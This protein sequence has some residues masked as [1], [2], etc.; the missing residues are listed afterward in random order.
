MLADEAEVHK[1]E[2]CNKMVPPLQISSYFG[3]ISA[4]RNY[5]PVMV[6]NAERKCRK[7]AALGAGC[8]GELSRG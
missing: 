5:F 1:M 6:R 7:R 3:D 4:L 8:F 2:K